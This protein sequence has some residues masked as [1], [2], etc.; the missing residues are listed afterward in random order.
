[1]NDDHL[2]DG[3]RA[4]TEYEQHPSK[5]ESSKI[6]YED[7]KSSQMKV[8]SNDL[9]NPRHPDAG[10][11]NLQEGTQRGLK[12]RHIQMI[13]LGGCIGTGLFLN[14]GMNVAT[15]GPAGA[16]IA[17]IVI[18]FMVYCIMTSLGEM[19]AFIP[20]S[21]SF[22]HY[23]TRFVDPA[24][25]FAL[26]WNYWFSSV[27]IATE[28]AASATIIKW[29]SPVM[30]DAAWSTI[31]L[32]L[33][34]A[35]N[36]VNVKIYGELEYYFAMIKILIVIVFIIIAILVSA[37]G[38][39]NQ[40]PIGFKYWNN[41]GA[42]AGGGVGTV[43]VLLSAGFSYQGT[44]VVGITAGEA[45]NPTKAVPRA[46]RNTFWRILVFYVATIF[47]IGL[48]VPADDPRLAN[49]DGSPSTS[50]M[51]LIF[52]LAG[53]EAGAHVINAIVLT[54]V[55]SAA[56][57]SVYTTARTLL[58][59]ARDGNGPA[60][61]AQTNRYG[62]PWIAVLLS[63]IC[64]FA[65]CFASIYS[66]SVAFSWFLAIT[67]V[68]GFISWW[69]I[70]FVHLRFRKAYVR[71][72]RDVNELPYKSPWYPFSDL[73]STILCVLI[74]LGQGY[75]AFSP[76]FVF[77][78]FA[79]N[80]VGIIPAPILYVCYKLIMRSKIVPL[81]EADFETGRVT[82]Y[83]IE[84]ADEKDRNRPWWRRALEYIL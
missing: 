71:Q 31:F 40:G 61:L 54:S 13:A 72:G 28:L 63:S 70:G 37:G 52:E 50:A 53:I 46:I 84:D 34:I 59:L 45:K 4:Y 68:S 42:F 32:V 38:V 29:W 3:H 26:G 73:F 65:A 15:A 81:E 76:E 24:L 79:A 57:S 48:C 64:G 82:M 75:T 78:T 49:D 58:G 20:V 17:Y 25:G 74:I 9:E 19:A 10:T 62:A 6:E 44:E 56:N 22:N 39:G 77:E 1:M 8:E 23:A 30:P 33:I 35:L 83:E 14:M 5:F 66:A 55:L 7:S 47:L 51:T 43:S 80:Y 21:G 36:L 27:T 18:G 41:P 60:I 11:E 2:D 16:F 67:T 69:G 12:T